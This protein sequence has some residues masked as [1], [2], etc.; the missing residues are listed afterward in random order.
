MYIFLSI[1]ITLAALALVLIV[2]IQNS[3]GGGLASGFAANNNIM[4]VRKTTD[5]LEK[6]TWWLVGIVFCLS[7]LSTVFVGKKGN[8]DAVETQQI[9]NEASKGALPQQPVGMPNFGNESPQAPEA[10][11]QENAT[12]Q[13]EEVKVDSLAN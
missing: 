10:A 4:G 1:L 11:T 6:T 13:S 7:V 9:I 5:V 8:V 2:V 12:S 3:K